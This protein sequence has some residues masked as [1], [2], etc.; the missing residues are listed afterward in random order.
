MTETMQK[1]K[2]R[3]E[4]ERKEKKTERKEKEK[5]KLS[6]QQFLG[7]LPL[8][9]PRYAGGPTK[10]NHNRSNE[11]I[12][13]CRS[14]SQKCNSIT[15]RE[16]IAPS[17]PSLSTEM[18]QLF[19]WHHSYKQ[20]VKRK[21]G[22]ESAAAADETW[23]WRFNKENNKKRY[24]TCKCSFYVGTAI[25][26]VTVTE[27]PAQVHPDEK[28]KHTWQLCRWKYLGCSA[29][30]SKVRLEIG[31]SIKKTSIDWLSVFVNKNKTGYVG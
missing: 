3:K 7:T 27:A 19:R 25:R 14:N 1:G 9:I 11:E 24:Q 23:Q 5:R 13:G 10:K 26:E 20:T 8:F 29:L 17:D 18:F 15:V 12:P 2:K 30:A 4:T 16:K 21:K 6:H 28:R 31:Q 22:K